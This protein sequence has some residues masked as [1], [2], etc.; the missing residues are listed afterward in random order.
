[1]KIL[2]LSHNFYPFLGGIEVN[3]ALLATSFAKAG[4][5]V[6][7]L[8]WTA[9]DGNKAFPFEVVRNPSLAQLFRAHLWT[10]MVFENNPCLRL[11]WLD[12]F[13]RRPL[14]VTLNTW[15]ARSSG[16]L[17][18]QD[19]LKFQWLKRAN[20]VVAVSEAVRKKCWPKATV[21]GNPYRADEFERLS[22]I[23]KDRDFVFLGRL[24]SDKGV[25][26]AIKAFYQLLS[27][28]PKQNHSFTIVGDGPERKKLEH[29]VNKLG[30]NDHVHFT[31]ALQGKV[32]VQCLN[33]HRFML[34]PSMWEEPFGNV[35]L[36]GIACGCI[37]IVSDGGGLPDAV[38]NAGITFRRG[39]LSHL[40][41]TIQKVLQQSS[42]EQQL[43]EAAKAHLKKHHPEEVC[44]QYLNVIIASVK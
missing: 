23:P 17:G 28:E 25:D 2:F 37:P 18:I 5:Q 32:L 40:V 7:L 30:L 42:L 16:R 11:S 20:S 22:S 26:L 14:V 12:F 6:L 15:I 24:V 44:R 1:M 3:S 36:E 43:R 19:K 9:E 34:V 27:K 39:N 8:T 31:G 35:A 38:G 41:D 4:H 10:D 33:R 13:T 29:M 21:I